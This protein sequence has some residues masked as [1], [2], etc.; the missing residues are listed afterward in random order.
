MLVQYITQ[1]VTQLEV[2]SRF[3]GLMTFLMCY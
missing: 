3:H 1:L 2:V